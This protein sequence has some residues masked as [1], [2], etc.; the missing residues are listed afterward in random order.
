MPS[1]VTPERWYCVASPPG[2]GQTGIVGTVRLLICPQTAPD[3][4][5]LPLEAMG[6]LG[7]AER[8]QQFFA[9]Q[10]RLPYAFEL[11]RMALDDNLTDE[12]ARSLG[13]HHAV[14]T[15]LIAGGIGFAD[16]C[17]GRQDCVVVASQRIQKALRAA[18]V[19]V[20]VYEGFDLKPE[21]ST[22]L[23][24]YA[25]YWLED[26]PQLCR[27]SVSPGAVRAAA[28]TLD[29]LFPLPRMAA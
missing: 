4:M 3:S 1:K 16:A 10:C 17:Y 25:R 19:D 21:Q 24:C 18:R 12:R 20:H 13:L 6:M 9:T 5:P 29:Q 14:I 28:A 15:L 7:S 8:W 27:L 23:Q 22:L 2:E 26:G 11:G